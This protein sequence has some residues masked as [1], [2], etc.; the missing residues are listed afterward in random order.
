MCRED[1]CCTSKLISEIDEQ[2]PLEF[3]KTGELATFN[4][5]KAHDVFWKAITALL[6]SETQASSSHLIGRV[7]QDDGFWFTHKKEEM[8]EKV[9]AGWRQHRDACPICK[10]LAN[11]RLL[12]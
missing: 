6:H 5:R 4:Q 12:T 10:K 3:L 9:R 7:V 1:Q 8:F 11:S 2:D